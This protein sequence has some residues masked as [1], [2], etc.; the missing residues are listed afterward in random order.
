MLFLGGN[1]LPLLAFFSCLGHLRKGV[2]WFVKHTLKILTN[3]PDAWHS[4]LLGQY[5]QGDGRTQQRSERRLGADGGQS[6]DSLV[7]LQFLVMSAFFFINQV[8]L[9]LKF[10]PLNFLENRK[11]LLTHKISFIRYCLRW[12]LSL[13]IFS[14][15]T[16]HSWACTLFQ[17]W[18][19]W[20][21]KT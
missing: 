13:G 7:S 19:S 5:I 12:F 21:H 20:G 16:R 18:Y 15:N 2:Y 10:I 8:L 4:G 11:V 6:D 3:T 14:V 9:S 1:F 17:K